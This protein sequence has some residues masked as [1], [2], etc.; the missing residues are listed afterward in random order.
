MITKLLDVTLLAGLAASARADY[1][2]SFTNGVTIP[3]NSANGFQDSHTLSGISGTISDVS[4]TLNISG[5]FDG[6]LYAWLSDGSGLAIL[7]NRVGVSSLNPV[8]YGNSGFGPD[9][10]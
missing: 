1:V 7:L 9:Q 4:V 6:D 3:D 8:G 10:Q 5:G 2:A